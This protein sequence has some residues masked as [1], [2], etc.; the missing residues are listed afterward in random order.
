MKR[1]SVYLSI[2]LISLSFSKAYPNDRLFM[3]DI[4]GF[5]LLP[6][7]SNRQ[8]D[9]G[10]LYDFDFQYEWIKDK[11]MSTVLGVQMGV[12][13]IVDLYYTNSSG[14]DVLTYRLK[15]NMISLLLEKRNYLAHNTDSLRGFFIA[16]FFKNYFLTDKYQDYQGEDFTT[17]ATDFGNLIVFGGRLGYKFGKKMVIE[18]SVSY[19]V[20]YTFGFS[21]SHQKQQIDVGFRRLTSFPEFK[22]LI[23][24]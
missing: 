6:L 18:P 24:F 20:G 1:K 9:E 11:K 3:T 17:E 2:L 14:S 19:G 7:I 4:Y 22:L 5:T 21:R 23:G 10:S 12:F 13:N 15:T 8:F 16:G